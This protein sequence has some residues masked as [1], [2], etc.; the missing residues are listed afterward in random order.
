MKQKGYLS[1][2][3]FNNQKPLPNL[4]NRDG[5]TDCKKGLN[6]IPFGESYLHRLE[7]VYVH[8]LCFLR[9]GEGGN[10]GVT[11]FFYSSVETGL[12]VFTVHRALL[13]LLFYQLWGLKIKLK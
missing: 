2:T 6:D 4:G 5:N 3:Q 7:A 10:T 13:Y 1:N 11:V 9:T 12:R 8:P